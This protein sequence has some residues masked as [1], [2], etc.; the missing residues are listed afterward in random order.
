MMGEKRPEGRAVRGEEETGGR[1]RQE[2]GRDRREEETVWSREGEKEDHRYLKPA[3]IE[4]LDPIRTINTH[5]R[6][7][8][9]PLSLLSEIDN[10]LCVVS[11]G[12]N[13]QLHFRLTRAGSD[14][15]GV[16][17]G[18]GEGREINE[19]VL[20]NMMHREEFSQE[21]LAESD[22]SRGEEEIET[23]ERRI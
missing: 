4:S 3:I 12:S 6:G 20:T 16:P 2:G 15:E 23:R 14:R 13:I 5:P 18:Q 9:R 11:Q 19:V 1:K 8:P 10:H 21:A 7:F 17:F 22:L